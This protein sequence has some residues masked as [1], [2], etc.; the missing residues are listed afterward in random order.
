MTLNKEKFFLPFFLHSWISFFYLFLFTAPKDVFRANA[1]F[2]EFMISITDREE[3]GEKKKTKNNFR[4]KKREC[5]T[6]GEMAIK[7]KTE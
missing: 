1:I 5:P 7:T 6:E 4:Q 3:M 2:L